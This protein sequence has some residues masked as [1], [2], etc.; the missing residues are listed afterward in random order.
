MQMHVAHSYEID[1]PELAVKDILQALPDGILSKVKKN[2]AV[3]LLTTHA[4]AIES[5]AVQAICDAI[6]CDV[7]GVTC[8]ASCADG[9]VGIGLL[10]FVLL[11]DDQITFHTAFTDALYDT[12]TDEGESH[13]VLNSYT[14]SSTQQASYEDIVGRA[15]AGMGFSKEGEKPALSILYGFFSKQ[16]VRQNITDCVSKVTGNTPLFG[17]FAS[18]HTQEG[19]ESYVIYNGQ[20]SKRRLALL[21]MTGA[22]KARFVFSSL[23]HS[24]I[25]S[26]ENIITSS[27]GEVV[28][29]VNDKPVAEYLTSFGISISDWKNML[30]VPFLVDYNDGTPLLA[31]EFLRLTPENNAVFGGE[32]PE[33]SSIFLS[34]QTADGIME[35]AE[36]VLE[37]IL[38]AKENI[39]GALV[40]SSA[41]RSWILGS[42]T[43]A[44]GEKA[45]EMIKDDIPYHQVYSR[46]EICPA[47]LADGTLQNRFHNFS[48]TLCMLEKI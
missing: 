24:N 46:G 8:L 9:E 2:H 19:S 3:G 42:K 14:E 20:C 43:L 13:S 29:T 22:V 7:L 32:M 28:H 5:G 23:S 26:T 40:V 41:G 37:Q 47:M 6:P 39:L 35:T 1:D 25:K 16:V 4:D 10:T 36:Q 48:F 17:G 33:G 44:E 27:K 12:V 11:M 45:L 18:D 30:M 38:L 34:F 15:Y 31:R 21:C